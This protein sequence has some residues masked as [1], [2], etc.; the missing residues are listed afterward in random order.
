MPPYPPILNHTTE[1]DYRAHFER[2]YCQKPILTFDGIE[3]RFRKSKFDHSFFE[4]VK[5][6]DD[7]FSLQRAKRMDW[8]KVALQDPHAEL[9]QGWDK[10][11]KRYDGFRRVA[12]VMGN[13][14]VVIALTG[15][16]KADF[17]TA[18]VADTSGRG[19]RPSTIDMIRMSPKWT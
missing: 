10:N 9:Y 19:T 6:K 16:N 14:V 13:Y 18:Y 17:I 12:V 11:R 2:E 7:T 15:D 4:S 5:A 1:A 8:I 3:V